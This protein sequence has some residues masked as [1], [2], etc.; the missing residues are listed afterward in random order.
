MNTLKKEAYF[1]IPAN[2]LLFRKWTCI[3]V[4]KSEFKLERLRLEDQLNCK[5]KYVW[6]AVTT[7]L[8][9]TH[10]QCALSLVT[11]EFE[12][13]F[14]C[15]RLLRFSWR[16]RSEKQ[17]F[18]KVIFWLSLLLPWFDQ[19]I[20]WSLL[21]W[22]R[23]AP[24][25]ACQKK[26]NNNNHAA[27]RTAVPCHEFRPR[28]RGRKK[29]WKQKGNNNRWLWQL[30]AA[31]VRKSKYKLKTAGSSVNRSRLNCQKND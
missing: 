7:Q 6:V 3:G 5:K 26:K 19:V 27:K 10:I 17:D 8:P 9:V 4:W 15:L 16:T 20:T 13:S 1:A 11:T 28:N 18:L 21:G 24:M 2:D 23:V 31:T 30:Y 14:I 25:L 12:K 29:K 22:K